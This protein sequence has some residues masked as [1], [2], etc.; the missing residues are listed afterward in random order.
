MSKKRK[1]VKNVKNVK[2]FKCFKICKK[3]QKVANSK[4]KLHCY[5]KSH[6]R[7]W[8]RFIQ[9]ENMFI[10]IH[11][12]LQDISQ[13]NLTT[14]SICHFCVCHSVEIWDISGRVFSK[15]HVSKKYSMTKCVQKNSIY[16][17]LQQNS[18]KTS[19]WHFIKYLGYVK[20]CSNHFTSDENEIKQIF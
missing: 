13:Y 19:F 11:L 10:S 16:S 14:I 20:F 4:S 3:S 15:A 1:K 12:T 9:K 7:F 5:L 6:S 2:W 17:R 18:Q 8:L